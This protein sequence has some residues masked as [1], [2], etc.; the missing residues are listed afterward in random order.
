[1]QSF[2]SQ[3]HGTWGCVMSVAYHFETWLTHALRQGRQDVIDS[4]PELLAKL[5]QE[6]EATIRSL[7]SAAAAELQASNHWHVP[8]LR[9][10]LLAK[11]ARSLSMKCSNLVG[12]DDNPGAAGPPGALD[13]VHCLHS[14]R[15]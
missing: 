8:S 7:S 1:M 3:L 15:H 2:L 14:S 9:Q 11:S 4:L 13:C 5:I 6:A 10:A 12:L